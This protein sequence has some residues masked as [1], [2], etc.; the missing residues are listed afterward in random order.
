VTLFANRRFADAGEARAV[1]ASALRDN[2]DVADPLAWHLLQLQ[3][4]ID[5]AGEFDVVHFHTDYLHY[6]M[7]PL[8]PPT[9]T[10]LHDSLDF[11]DLAPIYRRFTTPLLVSSCRSAV[12]NVV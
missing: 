8:L 6:P 1:R 5:R 7:N 4:V 2:A 3:E 9:V 12:D 11:P 10:T